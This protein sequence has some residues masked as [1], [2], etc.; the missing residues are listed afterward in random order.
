[1]TT[2][3]V[4]TS[5]RTGTASFSQ[6]SVSVA[7]LSVGSSKRYDS[8]SSESLVAVGCTVTRSASSLAS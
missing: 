4:S 5:M 7:D 6:R 8:F 3:G 1:M 2:A